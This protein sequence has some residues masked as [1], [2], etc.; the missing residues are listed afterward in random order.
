MTVILRALLL[1][2]AM[3]VG[4]IAGVLGSFAVLE[5]AFGL[6]SGLL[7]G[8]LIGVGVVLCAGLVSGRTTAVA[9]VLGWLVVVL[10]LASRRP[11]GDLVIDGSVSGY[12]WL[13]GG[14]LLLGACAALPYPPGL[15]RHHLSDR[16][17]VQ[18][19]PTV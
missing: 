8:L 14:T 13:F 12:A 16:V 17:R 6:P 5:T 4:A 1:A 7:L 18:E 15:R 3:T 11:E 9:A 19:P 2:A 10:L